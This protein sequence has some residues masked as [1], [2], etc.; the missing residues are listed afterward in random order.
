MTAN[1]R[2]VAFC[3]WLLA[4]SWVSLSSAQ[5]IIAGTGDGPPTEF[6]VPFS[7]DDNSW[8]LNAI[9]IFDPPA[10]GMIKSFEAPRSSSGGRIM[11]VGTQPVVFPVDEAFNLP[12]TAP[13]Q[14][15]SDWHEIILTPGWVWVLPG[16]PGLPGEVSLI[17]RDGQNWPW[18]PVNPNNTDPQEISV[19]FDA[20]GAGHVLDIHKGLL[21]V[22]TP[23]NPVW[24]D[25]PDELAILV[26]EYPTPEPSSWLL[27]TVG[28]A[29]L[30][31]WRRRRARTGRMDR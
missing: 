22:G 20:I 26:R 10:P 14:P 3:A 28:A 25:G 24:G 18:T 29:T 30:V 15:V 21:W 1:G 27:A 11:L 17:T 6:I 9:L 7:P 13:T 5:T 2:C 19:I 4:T 16:S 23:E 31:V 8:S 12:P